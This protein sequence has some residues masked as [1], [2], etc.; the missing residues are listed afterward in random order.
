[1]SQKALDG[2]G[3]KLLSAH[4]QAAQQQAAQQQAAQQQAAQNGEGS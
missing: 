2:L 4:Q 3:R 1:M